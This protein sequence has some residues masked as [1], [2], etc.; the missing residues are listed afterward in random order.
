MQIH[1]N[2]S[3]IKCYAHFRPIQANVPVLA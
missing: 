2:F 1:K 3:L